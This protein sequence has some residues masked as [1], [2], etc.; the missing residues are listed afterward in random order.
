MKLNKQISTYRKSLVIFAFHFFIWSA[1][2]ASNIDKIQWHDNGSSMVCKKN[3]G[4]QEDLIVPLVKAES[5]RY[6]KT[7]INKLETPI[8]SSCRPQQ[9]EKDDSPEICSSRANKVL[10]CGTGQTPVKVL[11]QFKIIRYL[12]L[13]L[14]LFRNEDSIN[15]HNVLLKN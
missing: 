9:R 8:Q 6:T 11:I 10:K 3:A 1:T 7:H 14:F 13:I 12:F 2:S 15:K 4:I 5:A